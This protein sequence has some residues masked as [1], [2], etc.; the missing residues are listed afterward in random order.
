[1]GSVSQ[2]VL[3][4]AQHPVLFCPHEFDEE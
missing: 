1:M 4:R 3:L 2:E